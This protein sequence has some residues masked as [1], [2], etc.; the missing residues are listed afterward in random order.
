MQS[1]LA[2][3][4]LLLW[5]RTS[6]G[7][8]GLRVAL[9]PAQL[10]RCS[11][12][13]AR[14]PA[15]CAAQTA[16]KAD[17]SECELAHF[18][19]GSKSDAMP[20]RMTVFLQAEAAVLQ[21]WPS[22]PTRGCRARSWRTNCFW[23]LLRAWLDNCRAAS[24]SQGELRWGSTILLR[25]LTVSSCW[26]LSVKRRILRRACWRWEGII[27]AALA[28]MLLPLSSTLKAA[29]NGTWVQIKLR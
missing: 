7:L 11:F 15:R 18:P 13:V 9:R 14:R 21:L 27:R 28:P 16:M 26:R 20:T 4:L 19:Q 23:K 10:P 25:P 3:C 24:L 8:G 5:S 29:Y 2:V 6:S 22:S 1:S 12:A 17:H